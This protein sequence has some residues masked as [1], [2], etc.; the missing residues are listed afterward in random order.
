MVDPGL[1]LSNLLHYTSLVFREKISYITNTVQSRPLTTISKKTT[2]LHVS[3]FILYTNLVVIMPPQT[4]FKM[5]T[6]I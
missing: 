3:Q 4:M 5:F 2:K 1:P 6:Q